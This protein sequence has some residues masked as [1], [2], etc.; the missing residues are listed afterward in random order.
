L[1]L[2]NLLSSRL[3]FSASH[4]KSGDGKEGDG[5]CFVLHKLFLRCW[6]IKFAV[7]AANLAKLR[8]RPVFRHGVKP[9]REF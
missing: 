8:R 7:A 6:L 5:Q 3:L 4:G 9:Y 2:L 1:N